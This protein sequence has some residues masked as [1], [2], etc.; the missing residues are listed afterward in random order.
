MIGLTLRYHNIIGHVINDQWYDMR[1]LL[2]KVMSPKCTRSHTKEIHYDKSHQGWFYRLYG[3]I[4]ANFVTR[5]CHRT[6]HQNVGK[7][8]IYVNH[9]RDDYINYMVWYT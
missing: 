8:F 1:K 7:K 6:V 3:M 2:Y 4:Y 9:T 5:S